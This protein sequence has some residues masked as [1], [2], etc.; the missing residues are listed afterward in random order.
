MHTL[1]L[2]IALGWLMLLLGSLVMA[3]AR[4]PGLLDRLLALDTLAVVL[5]AILA[6]FTYLTRSPHYLD[7]AL[8]LALV[9]FL[10]TVAVARYAQR[11]DRG[12]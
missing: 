11:Q 3:M 9:A 1:L 6:V 2:Y 4:L 12:A 5:V 10:G 7:A 8:A